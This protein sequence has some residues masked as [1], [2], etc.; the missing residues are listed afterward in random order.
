[1]R[2]E[3]TTESQA[4]IEKY[5][6]STE[7]KKVTL[8]DLFGEGTCQPFQDYISSP[9]NMAFHYGLPILNSVV[10]SLQGCLYAE[11][12]ERERFMN[13]SSKVDYKRM[14]R[15]PWCRGTAFAVYIPL[16]DHERIEASDSFV[17][18][19]HDAMA[20]YKLI[21]IE[22][23][24]KVNPE[25]QELEDIAGNTKKEIIS[26]LDNLT[27]GNDSNKTIGVISYT[28]VTDSIPLGRL[29][30]YDVLAKA[31]FLYLSDEST[32]VDH[33]AIINI[34]QKYDVIKIFRLF[35]LFF[36][37]YGHNQLL[38]E[39]KSL[40]LVDKTGTIDILFF[41]NDLNSVQKNLSVSRLY[42]GTTEYAMLIIE[43][44][45]E[46]RHG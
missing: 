8:G 9:E 10:S 6:K 44:I 39:E 4:D 30:T 45:L 37:R 31:I 14:E 35:A 15:Y 29:I 32:K 28:K 36:D 46:G 27:V 13:A 43:K 40:F 3:E 38:N 26:R 18:M 33:L 17:S 16:I 42:G 2:H 7:C 21:E 41:G 22:T 12:G 20:K 23:F 5:L 19:P 11:S 24:N 25:N 34:P 1:M